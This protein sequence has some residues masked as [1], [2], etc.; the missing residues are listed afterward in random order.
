MHNENVRVVSLFRGRG[1][2]ALF[3]QISVLSERSYFLKCKCYDVFLPTAAEGTLNMFEEAALRLLCI[4]DF[5]PAELCAQLCL[6][7]DLMAFILARLRSCGYLDDR[8]RP[9]SAGSM[10]AGDVEKVKMGTETPVH[11]L[12][13]AHTNEIF[14]YLFLP[15]EILRG[16]RAEKRVVLSIGTAGA[17]QEVKGDVYAYKGRRIPPAYLDG[18]DIRRAVRSYERHTGMRFPI[19]GGYHISSTQGGDVYLHCYAALQDG[20]VDYILSSFG[21]VPNSEALRRALTEIPQDIESKLKEAAQKIR[22]AGER[23]SEKHVR[24]PKLHDCLKE[25]K[26]NTDTV[27]EAKRSEKEERASVGKLL[28]AIE[29]ALYYHLQLHTLDEETMEQLTSQTNRENKEFFLAVAARVGLCHTEDHEDLFSRCSGSMLR[30]FRTE[31]EPS[32]E[33]LLPLTVAAAGRDRNA[34]FHD[35]VHAMP[36]LLPFLARMRRYGQSA[37]HEDTWTPE[38]GDTPA[39]LRRTTMR[40][41]GLML[42]DFSLTGDRKDSPLYS[43]SLEKINA[44]VSLGR[45]LGGLYEKLPNE[46][47]ALLR[48]VSPDKQGVELPALSDMTTTLSAILEHALRAWIA[49]IPAERETRTQEE[50]LSML[51][52]Q[53]GTVPKR[54]TDV[55][56]NFFQA[57]CKRGSSTLGG[58]ALALFALADADEAEHFLAAGL[59]AL[60]GEVAAARGHGNNVNLQMD[61]AACLDLRDRVFQMIGALS[62]EREEEEHG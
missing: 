57:A 28:T 9:T 38:E 13:P 31:A 52:A 34:A 14:P 35:I 32:L 55:R 10:A 24:Y 43:A 4:A 37:R 46:L 8:G 33:V 20:H 1:Y 39:G 11:I 29:W 51:R 7:P 47:R 48:K 18:A 5:S 25:K 41:I 19:P 21:H 50:V 16:E 45:A 61:E 27:D 6:A 44:D 3:P 54:L 26:S 36:D 30:R 53:S 58:Y 62:I 15:E 22:S 2:G 17:G 40:M 12:M 59:P 23:R 60:A 56:G 49:A 42:P